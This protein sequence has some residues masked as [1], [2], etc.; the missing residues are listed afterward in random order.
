MKGIDLK[1]FQK[2]P[3]IVLSSEQSQSLSVFMHSSSG[4]REAGGKSCCLSNYCS[5]I[6]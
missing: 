1:V 5:T 2:I 4:P 6:S 3:L